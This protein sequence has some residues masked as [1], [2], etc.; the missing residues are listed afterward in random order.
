MNKNRFDN[1]VEQEYILFLLEFHGVNSCVH[2]IEKK[3]PHRLSFSFSS[4]TA[5]VHFKDFKWSGSWRNNS[6]RCIE[7]E[8]KNQTNRKGNYAIGSCNDNDIKSNWKHTSSSRNGFELL[9]LI[10]SVSMRVAFV[11]CTR[12]WRSIEKCP[13]KRPT[14]QR[15][16]V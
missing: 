10:F 2:E 12:V 11:Q 5:N 15:M 16:Y 8:K 6:C 1:G 13:L 4:F 14:G 7:R 3:R 9:F